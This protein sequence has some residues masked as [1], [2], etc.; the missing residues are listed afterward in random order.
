M[1]MNHFVFVELGP[2]NRR[3]PNMDL[4]QSARPARRTA[5]TLVELLVVIAI[6]GVLVG[7]L[8]PAVQAAREAARRMQ[9]ANNLKQMGLAVHNYESALTAFPLTTTGPSQRSSPLG[10]GF[11]SWMAMVLP[12]IEQAPLYNSINFNV[13]MIDSKSLSVS[14]DY[15]NLTVDAS[16]PNALAAATLVPS[17]LCP[18]DSYEQ[19]TALGTARVAPGSY[20][21]NLGWVRGAVGAV[22]SSA[23][24]RSANG[25]MPLINPVQPDPWHVPRI[26]IGDFSDGTS[27]TA[28]IAERLINNSVATN[29]PVGVQMLGKAQPATL[30]Y[31]A[32]SGSSNRRLSDWVT[33]CKGVSIP[34]PTYS[35]P[36]G[37]S[38]ISGWTLAANLYMHVMPINA[39]NCHLY[40]GEDDGTNIVSASSNHVG[41]AQVCFVDGHVQFVSQNI[42]NQVWWAIGSRNGGEVV[43]ESP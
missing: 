43:S 9:C 19:T 2:L 41:G 13:S 6:I 14:D 4:I 1:N 34:D 37:R 36:H 23:P 7:L 38:W 12:Y 15:I 22:G 35:L 10:S 16:H 21:G 18:S 42:D 27:N 29:G 28:L 30:S 11:Y 32:G 24:L 8:L 40:G 3:S 31:C 39:R 33:F 17:F 26:R 20:A 5:F 25:A